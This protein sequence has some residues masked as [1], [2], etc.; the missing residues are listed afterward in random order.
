MVN[1][2][3]LY[4][5]TNEPKSGGDW[6]KAELLLYRP[7][8]KFSY[9]RPGLITY[10]NS[11][12]KSISYVP[13]FSRH[14]GYSIYRGTKIEATHHYE[15]LRSKFPLVDCEKNLGQ[16]YPGYP[17][18]EL[19]PV[20]DDEYILGFLEKSFGNDW[21]LGDPNFALPSHAPS[22]AYLKILEVARVVNLN[23]SKNDTIIEFGSAPGGATL[24]LLENGAKIF[25][26][27][28]GNMHELCT[29]HAHFVWVRKSIQETEKSD[30]GESIDWILSDMNLSPFAVLGELKKFFART[31]IIPSKGLILT[32]K[33]TKKEMLKDLIQIEK[34]VYNLGFDIHFMG[35][36][37][38]HNQEFAL[39]GK[40]R[41]F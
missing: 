15:L 26:V 25:G 4:F 19:V 40:K 17:C 31:Q 23:F 37:P 21:V 28:T 38:G 29:Q 34:K 18:F 11:T 20:K 24:A 2:K 6:L 32:L 7:E 27:D 5:L 9:S 30:F 22:R 13:I 14:F 3:F 1:K 16:K 41:N 10:I 12:E 35:Q 8:F 33:M 36:L 39:V